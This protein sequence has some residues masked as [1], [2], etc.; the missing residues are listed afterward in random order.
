MNQFP[1]V[2]IERSS[3]HG[4]F[5]RISVFG[6][7]PV[8]VEQLFHFAGKETQI[9]RSGIPQNPPVIADSHRARRTR[10]SR[11]QPGSNGQ[12]PS[13]T[14]GWDSPLPGRRALGGFGVKGRPTVN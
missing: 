9:R 7:G 6:I 2:P 10:S 14:A 12:P 1:P 5:K 4:P 11:T 8:G 13:P 3:K